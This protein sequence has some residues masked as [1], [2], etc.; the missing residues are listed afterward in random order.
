[1]NDEELKEKVIKHDYKFQSLS[2]SLSGIVSELHEITSNMKRVAVLNETMSNM[3]KNLKESF[4]RVYSK[5]NVNKTDIKEL[6]NTQDTTGCNALNLK[7]TEIETLN[8]AVFGKDGRGG[9]IFDVEDIKK[10]IYKIM[11]GFTILNITIAIILE[12]TIKG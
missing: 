5:I 2:E 9:L 10:F 4:T 1:M 11:G 7:A 8:R 3:D 12:M 6:K